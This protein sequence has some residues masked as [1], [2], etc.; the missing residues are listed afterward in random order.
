MSRKLKTIVINKDDVSFILEDRMDEFN[1]IITKCYCGQ[2]QD[3]YDSTIIN[4]SIR[5]NEIGD[6]ELDGVCKKCGNKMGRYIES[7]ESEANAKKAAAL[8]DTTKMLKEIRI[9][10]SK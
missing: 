3:G 8:W 6:L 5:L 1:Y 4:Y 7:G 10:K 2:C 9:K